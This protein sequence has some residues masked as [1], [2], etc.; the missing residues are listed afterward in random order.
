M[1]DL[2]IMGLP[3]SSYVRTALMVC[4]NKGVPYTLEP[5][6]FRAEAYR[7]MHPFAKM[8]A[9]AHGDVT[10]YEALAIAVYVDE[11]FDGP[12]MQPTTPEG[13]ARMMQ[14]ISVVNDYVYDQMVGCCVAEWFVKP[15]RGLDPDEAKIAAAV[16]LIA[17]Q[18]DVLENGIAGDYICGAELTLADCFVAPVLHYFAATPE[19]KDMLPARPR[20]SAWLA[21]MAETPGF[22]RVNALGAG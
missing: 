15:M 3:P 4:E 12:T 1:T 17:H 16:P 14:W 9:L 6:D 13:P 7:A 22:S 18:L 11:A 10:L 21:R 19:G 8:P 2:V 5:V 20:L